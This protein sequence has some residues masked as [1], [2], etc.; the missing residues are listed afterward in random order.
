MAKYIR[1]AGLKPSIVLCTS[2]LRARETLELLK[3]ALA[4]GTA[5]KI[6]PKL[7]EAGSKELLTRIRRLSP[8]APSVLIIGHNPA[9]QELVL[10]LASE[11]SD[12]KSVRKKFPTAALAVLNARAKEWKQL[13]PGQASLE[14]FITPKGLRS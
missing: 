4:D 11:S 1:D 5:I 6:E 7:Y 13:R 8:A 2:T 14:E 10:E 3:P 9:M 12:A